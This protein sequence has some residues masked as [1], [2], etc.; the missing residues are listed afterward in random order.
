MP[1]CFTWSQTT[2][3]SI[4]GL[5]SMEL[6]METAHIMRNGC[7]ICIS[8]QPLFS[9]CY[10]CAEPPP[11]AYQV[12]ISLTRPSGTNVCYWPGEC[13][14]AYRYDGTFVMYGG[15]CFYK[16]NEL[17]VILD[18]LIAGVPPICNGADA[19][20]WLDFSLRPR[21]TMRIAQVNLGGGLFTIEYQ[22]KVNYQIFSWPFRG[23]DP[24]GLNANFYSQV[25]EARGR[26]SN[27]NC[28][29]SVNGMTDVGGLMVAS[30]RP[31]S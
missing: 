30:V 18:C 10:I 8:P 14:S 1:D 21:V 13:G 5:C 4:T 23:D 27:S 12:T 17:E 28:Y 7:P 19:L 25:I 31:L 2:D 11:A 29:E 6:Q 24:F 20:H 9:V 26:T 3:K 15:D 22:V 16:S